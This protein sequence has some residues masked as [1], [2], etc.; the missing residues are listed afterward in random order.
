MKAADETDRPGHAVEAGP[1][2]GNKT[3]PSG[4]SLAACLILVSNILIFAAIPS[5]LFW[6]MVIMLF[7]GNLVGAAQLVCVAISAGFV[8]WS[9]K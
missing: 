3:K 9:L 1:A 4:R 5:L 7:A 6:A 8:G 2:F